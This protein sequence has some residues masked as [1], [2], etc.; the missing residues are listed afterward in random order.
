MVLCDK[1]LIH[2]RKKD[3]IMDD[4]TKTREQLIRDVQKLRQS[5]FDIQ[6]LQI[7]R[8]IAEKGKN[9]SPEQFQKTLEEVKTLA[10]MLPI[11]SN[12]K[13]IRDDSGCWHQVEKYIKSH[14]KVEFTHG[15]CP[16]C[17]KDVCSDI[18]QQEKEGK[19]FVNNV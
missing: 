4:S 2:L 11:C 10:G 3:T 7:Q 8:Q 19:G 14:A 1:I 15:L 9:K 12:C 6:I 18:G 16:D 17:Y 5:L 13:K